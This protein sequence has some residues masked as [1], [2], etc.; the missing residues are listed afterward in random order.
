MP[1]RAG[2]SGERLTQV[3]AINVLFNI[4]HANP[5]NAVYLARCNYGQ[6]TLKQLVFLYPVAVISFVCQLSVRQR[7]TSVS[8][9]AFRH[10]AL[11]LRRTAHRPNYIL[12][13]ARPCLAMDNQ[14]AGHIHSIEKQAVILGRS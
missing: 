10:L 14:H 2:C 5:W 8:S 13:N 11:P 4:F 9:T 7:L 12:R 1:K 6:D 3:V